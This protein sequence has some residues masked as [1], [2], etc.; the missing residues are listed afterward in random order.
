MNI[1]STHTCVPGWAL[2]RLC[3]HTFCNSARYCHVHIA[4]FKIHKPAVHKSAAVTTTFCT[5]AQVLCGELAVRH[6]SGIWSFEVDTI[7]W[8]NCCTSALHTPVDT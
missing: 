6:R 2:C 1:T 3:V 5:V 8:G 4:V 7:F